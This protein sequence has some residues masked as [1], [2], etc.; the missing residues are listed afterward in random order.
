MMA[1]LHH[2]HAHQPHHSWHE[3]HGTHAGSQD[4][5]LDAKNVGTVLQASGLGPARR[6]PLRTQPKHGPG[7]FARIHTQQER[8]PAGLPAANAWL[9]FV[10]FRCVSDSSVFVDGGCHPPLPIPA[11][12]DPRACLPAAFLVVISPDAIALYA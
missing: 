6:F 8:A 4:V 5:T 10:L 1:K 3:N 9:L 2:R 7:P 11:P 12:A